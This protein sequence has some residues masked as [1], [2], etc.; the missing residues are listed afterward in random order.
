MNLEVNNS[1]LKD[2][3]SQIYIN[4]ANLIE[5]TQQDGTKSKVLLFRIP[6][7]SLVP[8]QKVCDKVIT[9]LEQ[10]FNWPVIIVATRT[11]ISKRAIHHKSQKRPRS[12]T[13]TAVHNAILEDI[14]ILN[15][16]I[17]N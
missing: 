3:L 16:M 7:R 4:S 17:G 6:F 11:I 14:V 15:Y 8:Y 5:Y 9:H 13:L 12:R 1:S 2:T 10:K